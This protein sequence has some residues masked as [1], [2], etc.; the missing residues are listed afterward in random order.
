MALHLPIGPLKPALGWSRYRDVNP[1][2]T[3]PLADDIAT[4]ACR[5]VFIA[6]W[7]P[8]QGALMA[9]IHRNKNAC[10]APGKMPI[11]PL[12]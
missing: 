5:A 12:R 6:L 7:A 2:P 8:G 9:T 10:W 4:V 11:G 3:S 1:V